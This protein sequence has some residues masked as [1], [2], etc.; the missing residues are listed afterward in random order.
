MIAVHSDQLVGRRVA[1]MDCSILAKH[2]DL[3]IQKI[4]ISAKWPLCRVG[5]PTKPVTSW[6]LWATGSYPEVSPHWDQCRASN[7]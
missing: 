2:I 4:N 7:S 5:R 6:P 1:A 3:D